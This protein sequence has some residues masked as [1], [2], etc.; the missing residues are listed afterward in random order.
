MSEE[1]LSRLRKFYKLDRF[2][3]RI[4]RWFSYLAA[5]CV[6]LMALIA[7]VNVIAQK[8][9]HSNISSAN[10]YVTY[11][12]VLIIYVALP[13]V[14]METDLT[15]VDILSSR[16]PKPMQLV[17]SVLGD[18]IG[19]AVFGFVSYAIYTNVFV[20][21]L[22]SGKVATVGATGT[23]VLWPF[24]LLVSVSALLTALSFIWNN[25]RRV[26]YRGTKFIPRSL[27]RELGVEPPKRF[28]PGEPQE[29]GG[30]R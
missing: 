22:A 30:N 15:S 19:L 23:F 7:T 29:E 2:I 1:R 16:F 21:Y 12:F 14:Q 3:E 9:F 13:H 5:V 20:K 6:I 26:M 10:D 4:L 11:L 27:C 18:I 17:I 24:A 8:L 25:V 28:G